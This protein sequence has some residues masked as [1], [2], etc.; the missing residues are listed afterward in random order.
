MIDANARTEGDRLFDRDDF[1]A[2]G[3]F[4]LEGVLCR[5]ARETKELGLGLI[6]ILEEYNSFSDETRRE[7]YRLFS[8]A[9]GDR[10]YPIQSSKNGKLLDVV[11][12]SHVQFLLTGNPL[13]SERY[14]TDDLKRLSNAETR[15]LVILYLDYEQDRQRVQAILQAIIRKKESFRRLRETVTDVEERIKWDLGLDLFLALNRRGEGETLGYDVGYTQIADMLWTAFLRSHRPD[16]LVIAL[17]EHILNGIAD[18]N[19]RGLAAERIRQAVNVE[20][21]KHIL[22]RDA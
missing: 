9:E 16:H 21:P 13:S 22:M 17:T 12:F 7:F 6:V 10:T 15:R 2:E 14:L 18:I 4:I 5:L 19:L 3:T 11:D 8:D 20:V 1:D